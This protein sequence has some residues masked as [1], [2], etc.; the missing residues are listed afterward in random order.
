MSAFLKEKAVNKG[1]CSISQISS[2]CSLSHV[3]IHLYVK[4]KSKLLSPAEESLLTSYRFQASELTFLFSC[5]MKLSI[6]LGKV[7]T[8]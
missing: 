1:I 4:N 6:H 3:M 2:I 7:N 8:T 5:F